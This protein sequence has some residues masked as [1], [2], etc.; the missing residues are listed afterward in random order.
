M[1]GT[2]QPPEKSRDFRPGTHRSQEAHLHGKPG[3]HEAAE[4]QVDAGKPQSPEVH[5]A[6]AAALRHTQLQMLG[7]APETL[8]PQLLHLL[9]ACR[10]V[11]KAPDPAHPSQI[12]KSSPPDASQGFPDR[13]GL[14]QLLGKSSSEYS[15]EGGKAPGLSRDL[16]VTAR[17]GGDSRGG[18]LEG[19]CRHGGSLQGEPFASRPKGSA[20]QEV[21]P[22]GEGAGGQDVAAYARR[23][24]A[25]L[26][27]N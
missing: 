7:V 6:A 2:K 27:S 11:S 3:P 26:A 25:L 23:L 1:A 5:A 10:S 13:E 4:G 17:G 22:E 18:A 16:G 15:S 19:E 14:T 24:Y 21:G 9:S 20:L 8:P 12:P